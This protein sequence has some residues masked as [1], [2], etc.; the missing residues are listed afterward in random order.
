MDESAKKALHQFGKGL[1]E[2]VRDEELAFLD[3]LTSGKM[4]NPR[5]RELYARYRTL[6]VEDAELVRE[7]FADAV[8]GAI[9][10]FL[11]YLDEY[12]FQLF[13]RDDVEKEH[14]IVAASDGLAGELYSKDGWI[15]RFSRYPE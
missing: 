15:A 7:M 14:D 13:T 1:M 6:N 4:A 9:A 10:H 8:V 2:H 3:R 11:H 12:Q 5:S